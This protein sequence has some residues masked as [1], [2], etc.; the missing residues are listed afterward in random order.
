VG[1]QRGNAISLSFGS[2]PRVLFGIEEEATSAV[3]LLNTMG[4]AANVGLPMV[5]VKSNDG[6]F[7]RHE[8][9]DIQKSR[10]TISIGRDY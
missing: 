6:S 10:K 5:V 8:P 1:A 7:S 2:Q 4:A 9:Q 3:H